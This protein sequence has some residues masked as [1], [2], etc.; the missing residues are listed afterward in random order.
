MESF[1]KQYP[2]RFC[3]FS[4]DWKYNRDVHETRKHS[5]KAKSESSHFTNLEQFSYNNPMV[6]PSPLSFSSTSSISI[7]NDLPFNLNSNDTEKKTLREN[8]RNYKKA[9]W[10]FYNTV[11]LPSLSSRDLQLNYSQSNHVMPRVY[12]VHNTLPKAY[13]N[14]NCNKCHTSIFE[15][16]F[17]LQNINSFECNNCA[18]QSHQFNYC[19]PFIITQKNHELLLSII[20][21]R[22]K[23]EKIPLKMIVFPKQFI[24]NVFCPWMLNFLIIL[25]GGNSNDNSLIG[26]FKLSEIMRLFKNERF[27]DLGETW[28]SHSVNQAYDSEKIILLEKEKLKQFVSITKGTFGLIKFKI[29]EKTI[30]ALGYIPFF[31]E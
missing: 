22:I 1:H 8:E 4:S 5:P 29:N 15:A 2:C 10:K 28:A 12:I 13:K 18:F 20:Y 16:L 26:I 6:Q 3:S 27:F 24:E 31:I 17:N 25:T 9:F 23:T 7:I 19:D 30:Y 14:Y 21:D 11:V